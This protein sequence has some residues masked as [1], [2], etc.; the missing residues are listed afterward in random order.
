MKIYQNRVKTA[1]VNGIWTMTCSLPPPVSWP[2]LLERS[3]IPEGCGQEERGPSLLSSQSKVTIAHLEGQ[4]TNISHSFQ[5]Q[6]E[7]S[8]SLF[9]TT[10]KLE[11][12]FL[13]HIPPLL[14]GQKLNPK[15]NRSRI[16]HP[17][18]S[19]PSSFTGEIPHWERKRQGD[20]KL[21]GS[22]ALGKKAGFLI[23]LNKM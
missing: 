7:A 2:P 10:E 13:P 6:D 17:D 9:S 8:K 16:C 19:C 3:S 5:F 18:Y 15:S 14:I 21:L 11:Q 12:S 1:R 23:F 22:P 4:A 20:Q